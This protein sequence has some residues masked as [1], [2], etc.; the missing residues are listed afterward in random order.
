MPTETDTAKTTGSGVPENAGLEPGRQTPEGGSRRTGDDLLAAAAGG[1]ALSQ[2]ENDDLVA[3]YLSNE[4]L[5]G[6]D[7]VHP[8]TVELGHGKQKKKFRCEVHTIEWDDWQDAREK[9]FDEK[10][11]QFDAYV[12]SSW[13]VGRALVKPRLG[14]TVIRLQKE[15]PD[16]APEHAAELLQRMFRKQ[17]G[18]L[19]ELSAKVLE[20]SKLQSDNNS[21]QEI[22][23][24]KN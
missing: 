16:T 15:K 4:Q 11:N 9:A 13:V 24:A 20:L 23:A 22:E 19:L 7:E 2:V 21:V 5:P 18:A 6:D 1:N 8:L 10:K 3:Y 17:S 14:P 12:S